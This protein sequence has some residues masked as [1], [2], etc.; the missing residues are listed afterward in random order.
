MLRVKGEVLIIKHTLKNNIIRYPPARQ[1]VANQVFVAVFEP[2]CDIA[3]LTLV[4]VAIRVADG[5][6]KL[7]IL[8]AYMMGT[9]CKLCI[10]YKSFTKAFSNK[11]LLFITRIF[12]IADV[13][14][15][16]SSTSLLGTEAYS[17]L[18]IKHLMLF[19]N[20]SCPAFQNPSKSICCS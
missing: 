2:L 19:S 9:R 3:F 16:R 8:L 15:V 17:S 10:L 6:W 7:N 1:L 20:L 14:K 5:P 13:A 18:S 11:L 4:D 12:V